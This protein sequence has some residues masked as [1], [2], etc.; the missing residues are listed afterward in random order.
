MSPV[1][2][3]YSLRSYNA[4]E[5][6]EG[7]LCESRCSCLEGR[8]ASVRGWH[9]PARVTNRT[10]HERSTLERGRP[11][12]T[13]RCCGAPMAPPRRPAA[14]PVARN[15]V[16]YKIQIRASHHDQIAL[17]TTRTTPRRCSIIL[18]SDP[19]ILFHHQIARIIDIQ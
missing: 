10:R 15:S 13:H 7:V 2:I 16:S 8:A 17:P 9:R 18:L 4:G 12:L 3:M 11:A 6:G 14:G 19:L 5:V 1:S